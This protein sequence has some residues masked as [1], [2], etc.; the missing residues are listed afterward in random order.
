M[1]GDSGTFLLKLA[2]IIWINLLLSGD[3]A[4]VIAL[5]CRGLPENLRRTGILAG[6]GAAIGLRVIFTL[7]YVQLRTLPYLTL[8]SGLLLFWIAVKL[9]IDE[10]SHGHVSASATLWKAV[11]TIAIA[12]AVMSLDNVVAIVAIAKGSMLLIVIGLLISIPMIAFGAT[13]VLAVIDRQH[14]GMALPFLEHTPDKQ[15]TWA[16]SKSNLSP[17]PPHPISL[18]ILLASPSFFSAKFCYA[19]CN[20]LVTRVCL[21]ELM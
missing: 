13:L 11:Q 1:I 7:V 14:C 2:Q 8:V 17:R 5:A 6:S 16:S 18:A 12:D 10:E 9:V 20:R 15:L 21:S 3:N 4:V 19:S